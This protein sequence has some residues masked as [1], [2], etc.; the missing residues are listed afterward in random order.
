MVLCPVELYLHIWS[1]MID[2]NDRPTAP[3]GVLYQTKLIGD[4]SYI[5]ANVSII[6]I[7][8]LI[9]ETEGIEPSFSA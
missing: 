8:V 3:N 7:C 6:R 2:S 4:N 1:P 5:E 9:G